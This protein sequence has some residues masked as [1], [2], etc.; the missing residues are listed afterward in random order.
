[1][2][3]VSSK[4]LGVTTSCCSHLSQIVTRGDGV[5]NPVVVGDAWI[6]SVRCVVRVAKEGRHF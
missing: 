3:W 2:Q 6:G 5:Q 1:M 4:E